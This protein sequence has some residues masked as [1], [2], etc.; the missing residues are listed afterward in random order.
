MRRK[1]GNTN[2]NIVVSSDLNFD[3]LGV[4]MAGRILGLMKD[5]RDN[6]EK[7]IKESISHEGSGR[8][9]YRPRW[10]GGGLYQ[11]SAPGQPPAYRTGMLYDSVH[12]GLKVTGAT[13]IKLTVHTNEI[14]PMLEYGTHK[15]APRPFARPIVKSYLPKVRAA[16]IRAYTRN[17]KGQ[18]V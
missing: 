9:Y 16:S 6:I 18:F 8:F 2:G 5:I 1:Y 15:I 4:G 7:E 10:A 12:V 13:N 17:W 3:S 14:G 11:A